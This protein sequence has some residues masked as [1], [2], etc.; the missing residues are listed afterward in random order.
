MNGALLLMVGAVCFLVAYIFYG[1]YL[2]RLFGVDPARETPAHTRRDGVDYLPTRLPVLFGH[3]FASIAG[4]GPIVGPVLAAFLGW[5]PVVLWIIFGCI[6]IGAMHDF[7][8]LFLS[9]RNG[10][11]SVGHVIETQLGYGGR[12][13]FLLFSWAALVLVVAIFAVLVARTFVSTPAVAT[14][15]LLFIG[16]APLFGYLVNRRR[17]QVLPAT[18]IFVPL[19]FMFIWLGTQIPLDL[20][21]FGLSETAAFRTWLVILF[22]YAGLAS[23]VPVWILLQP[24]DYLNSF[25]L[26]AMMLGGFVGILVA[27]P[28]FQMPAFTG[29]SAMNHKGGVAYLFPILYVTVAC[30]ACS[31]FHALVS[32]G[33]TAKQ[34]DTERDMKPVGYGAMLVEGV[35]ALMALTSV[36][37]LSQADYIA[38]LNTGSP[39]V[40]F[41][42]GLSGFTASIGLNPEVGMTFFAMTIAAFLLTTLDTATRLTR[43]VWQELFLPRSGETAAAGGVRKSLGGPAVATGLAVVLS[44]YLAFSGNAWDIWPIFGASNQL[45]AALTLLIVTLYL[46]RK[47]ANF[48][49]ALV[50][51]VFMSTITVWALVQL[52]TTNL[53]SGGRLSLVLATAFLLV[54]AMILAIQSVLSLRAARSTKQGA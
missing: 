34:L 17:V 16:M 47:K 54:M 32:S 30:G 45:L 24:R 3:H 13:I 6:F 11:R 26:Y 4:A 48:W 41:A 51:M 42:R 37:C 35:L 7:A 28:H 46:V 10:G 1:R 33:T 25:L 18:I 29:W 9:V 14:A 49:I 27:A 52:L 15:S 12:Q 40:L 50:P 38:G 36:A 5:G 20:M 22:A 43:F 39:V 23:V 2:Q 19:L 8:S 31:G 53:K 21:Q 44:G